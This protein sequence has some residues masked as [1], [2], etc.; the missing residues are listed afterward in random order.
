[1]YDFSDKV[2]VVTGAA[3]G[4]GYA[5]VKRYLKENAN[6]VVILDYNEEALKKAQEALDPEK[7][8]TITVSCDVSDN[9][10]VADA[11]K[12][13][14]EKFGSVDILVNNAGITRDSMFHKMTAAQFDAVLK[15]SLYGA[16]NCSQQV[17]KGM[18]DKKYGKIVSLASMS[19]IN[20][21][22]GQTNYSAAKAG[23]VGFTKT[24]A[25]ENGPKG[26]NVNAI[27]PGMI[28]TDIIKTVPENVQEMLKSKIPMGRFGEPDEIANL[29]MFLSSDESSY[30]S[31]QCIYVTGGY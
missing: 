24:L 4:L 11:F 17:I 14:E 16:F 13:I 27:A 22:I 26:V 12:K 9:Q 30:I 10:A 19:G 7:E 2:I 29:I 28:N 3:Q 20:G 31:G 6:K 18:R 5:T 15:V 25:L 1:M 23:I 21:N 8:K